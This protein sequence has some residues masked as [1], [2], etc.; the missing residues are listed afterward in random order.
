MVQVPEFRNQ[1]DL[2]LREGEAGVSQTGRGVPSFGEGPDCVVDLL[3]MFLAGAFNRPR[4]RKRKE[5]EILERL[6]KIPKRTQEDKSG[7]TGGK[8]KNKFGRYVGL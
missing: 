1:G 6:G 4:K 2:H 3:G 7:R 5:W 8:L